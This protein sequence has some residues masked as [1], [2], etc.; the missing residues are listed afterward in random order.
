MRFLISIGVRCWALV[1]ALASSRP[2]TERSCIKEHRP[3]LASPTS[4]RLILAIRSA[5][6]RTR[7]RNRCGLL[8]NTQYQTPNT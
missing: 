4:P 7:E 5:R 2:S 1:N 6:E 3:H 8:P